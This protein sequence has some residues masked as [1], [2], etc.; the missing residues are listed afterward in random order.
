MVSS[1]KRTALFLAAVSF[2]CIFL[3]LSCG[4]VW[5]GIKD[6]YSILFLKENPALYNVFAY[7]RIPRTMA[8]FFAGASL[9][10]S[11]MLIQTVLANPLASPN[12]IGVNA[13]AGLGAVICSVLLPY[14]FNAV[15]LFSCLFAV[16]A[17]F[18]IL[19]LAYKTNSS[20]L[21]IVL[22]GLA[23]SQ[24]FNAA[25]DA[26]INFFPDVLSGYSDFKM[27]SLA[28][29][30]LQ[31]TLPG[32]IA[33][34]LCLLVLFFFSNELDILS[35]GAQSA[36]SLGLN[37]RK[38]TFFFLAAAALLAGCAVSFCGMLSFVGLI[39]PHA[40]KKI[41]GSQP[42]IFLFSC[43]FSG[44]SLVLLCDSLCRILFAPFEFPVGILMAFLGGP[45]FLYLIFHQ[46]RGLR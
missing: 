23:V 6:M 33:I 15:P 22:A 9:A 17:A 18:L 26:I 46:R 10:A 25:S 37:A 35:L 45:F 8:G 40:C 31:Q 34:A 16:L 5:I 27:G 3:S 11:G 38:Y 19:A 24:I 7:V 14:S 1:K 13:G 39:V 44:G 29:V 2:I 36:E 30:S 41:V 42:K 32:S 12:I 28:Q 20:K 21:T 4:S 43:I